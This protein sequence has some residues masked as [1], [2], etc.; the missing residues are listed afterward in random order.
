MRV[1]SGAV[2]DTLPERDGAQL[3]FESLYRPSGVHGPRLSAQSFKRQVNVA[4][5]ERRSRTAYQK[6]VDVNSSCDCFGLVSSTVS[7]PIFIP[8]DEIEQFNEG[9]GYSGA[10]TR[11]G[12]GQRTKAAVELRW[13]I[14]RVATTAKNGPE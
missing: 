6:S 4:V 8:V 7:H 11:E 1:R 13:Q 9:K 12:R 2:S 3:L 5:I 14:Q 10:S